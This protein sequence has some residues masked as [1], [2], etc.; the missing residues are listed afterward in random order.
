LPDPW[1]GYIHGGQVN[2]RPMRSAIGMP[3]R[4]PYELLGVSREA[5]GD[6]VRKAYRRLAREH[7]PDANADDPEAEERFKDIHQAYEVLSNPEKRRKYDERLRVTSR[8]SRS[9][10][11]AGRR[12]KGSTTSQVNI[13]N[14]LARLNSLSG[15]RR[16]FE[17]KLSGEDASRAAKL[18]G[19][20]LDHLSKLLGEVATVQAQATFGGDGSV[21]QNADRLGE[22]PPKPPIPRKPPKP[23]RTPKTDDP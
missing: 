5:S 6:D 23:P 2:E 11:A 15:R 21:G 12:S 9:S 17:W 4:D 14:L 13:V 19:V 8:R 10:A 18:F 1:H 16:E 20:D 22:R 7:H 3:T